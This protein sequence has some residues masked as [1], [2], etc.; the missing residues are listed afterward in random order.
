MVLPELSGCITLGLQRGRERY[1]LIRYADIGAG[2][3]DSGQPRTQRDFT[4]DEVGAPRGATRFRVVVGK[5]HTL[6]GQ[7]VEIRRFSR[8]DSLV[9][10]ANVEPAD[11]VA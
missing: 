4:G 10:G 11:V 8:H 9:V 7:L 2:L 3:A 6:R 1:S 5:P